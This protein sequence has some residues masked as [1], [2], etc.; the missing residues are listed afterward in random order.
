MRTLKTLHPCR[1]SPPRLFSRKHLGNLFAGP[2]FEPDCYRFGNETVRITF[3]FP[4][5]I[6]ELDI[7]TLFACSWDWIMIMVTRI[8]SNLRSF[9]KWEKSKSVSPVGCTRIAPLIPKPS[10]NINYFHRKDDR[11]VRRAPRFARFAG[12]SPPG[13]GFVF[14]PSPCLYP[15]WKCTVKT[16]LGS[17]PGIV[18]KANTD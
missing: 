18:P 14:L 5:L 16:C 15:I 13:W 10:L 6:R 17:P 4:V 3:P 12:K 8:I 7:Q 9:K 2:I 11:R 1:S